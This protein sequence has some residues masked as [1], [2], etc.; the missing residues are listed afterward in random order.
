MSLS[1]YP[2]IYNFPKLLISLEQTQPELG[3]KTSS[4]NGLDLRSCKHTYNPVYKCAGI[5]QGIY[6]YI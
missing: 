2:H 6:E 5:M 4:V 1:T 3:H